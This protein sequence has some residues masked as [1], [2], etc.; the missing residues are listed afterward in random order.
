MRA[1]LTLIA[2]FLS[3]CAAVLRLP[4]TH[5]RSAKL[6]RALATMIASES[7]NVQ[8]SPLLLLLLLCARNAKS[9]HAA[10]Q[11]LH[12]GVKLLFGNVTFFLSGLRAQKR[13]GS[14]LAESVNRT[15]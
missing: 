10:R 11:L 5:K 8:V 9:L 14:L 1:L 15:I 13:R 2:S 3:V 7:R 12:R 6:F 4:D